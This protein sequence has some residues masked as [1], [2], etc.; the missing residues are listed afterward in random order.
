MADLLIELDH[1]ARARKPRLFAVFGVYDRDPETTF[2]G[3]G[4]EF[5]LPR[6]AI[7]WS[8]DGN[9]W[10]SGSAAD[11]LGTHRILGECRLVWLDGSTTKDFDLAG[12]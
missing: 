10:H 1:E 9:T 7:M 6:Q 5:D 2:L 8:P 11:I 12:G 4:M 3:W